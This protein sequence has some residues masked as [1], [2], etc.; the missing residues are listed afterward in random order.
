MM[1]VSS[2]LVTNC[3]IKK[4][5]AQKPAMKYNKAEAV[6]TASEILEALSQ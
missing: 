5:S 3:M 2:L 4:P 1:G 6:S